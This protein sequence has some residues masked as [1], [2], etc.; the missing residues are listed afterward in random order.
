MTAGWPIRS[1][2][3]PSKRPTISKTTSWVMKTHSDGPLWAPGAAAQAK[4]GRV[5]AANRTSVPV[6]RFV[7]GIGCYLALASLGG[8]VRA[9][10]PS[11]RL[12]RKCSGVRL[13]GLA[14]NAGPAGGGEPLLRQKPALVVHL[15]R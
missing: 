3:S 1:M 14:F 9:R 13:A 6:S 8:E 15:A 2:V 11:T 5:T 10:V 7:I 4:M 12:P